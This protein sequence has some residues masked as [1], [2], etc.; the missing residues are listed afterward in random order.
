MK[1]LIIVGAGGFGREALYLALAINNQKKQWNILGFIDD[2]PNALDAVQCDYRIIGKISE[3]QPKDSEVF[4]MGIST[5]RTKEI[6]SKILK[7]KGASFVTLINPRVSIQPFV[8]I[9]EGCI[10]SGNIGDNCTIGDFVHIAGSIIGQDSII[11]DYTTTTAY[12]NVA[13]ASIGKRVFIGSHAMILNHT[14]V[15]DDAEI[16]PGSMVI[17]KVK[18]GT[19]VFGMPAKKINI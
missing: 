5:P 12:V 3:W 2:N 14:S 11:G 10:I 9:G 13:S 8:T 17:K 15:G 19:K 6:V 16:Y 4:A 18:A 7:E 1:N